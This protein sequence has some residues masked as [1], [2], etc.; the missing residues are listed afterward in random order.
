MEE[1]TLVDPEE[2]DEE[3]KKISLSK[4]IEGD[5][6]EQHLRMIFV[7]HHKVQQLLLEFERK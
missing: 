7:R 5:A 6:W 2:E 4:W 3:Q 1:I